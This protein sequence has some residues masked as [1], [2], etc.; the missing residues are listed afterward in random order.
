MKHDDVD[1]FA[2]LVMPGML[3]NEAANCLQIGLLE[4]I[5]RGVITDYVL[6]T[7]WSADNLTRP[8][9][10]VL[11]TPPYRPVLGEPAVDTSHYGAVIETL[12]DNLPPELPGVLGPVD[13]GQLFA[14]RYADK[15]GVN[16]ELTMAE[17]IHQCIAVEPPVQVPGRMI[18]AEE[19]YK[20]LLVDWWRAFRLETLPGEPDTAE[21]SVTRDLA[22][23]TGGIW[24]WEVE[25]KPVSVAGA[26]GP[27]P[28]G[29]RVGP[30]YTPP[31]ERRKG[32]AA[33]LVAQVTQLLLDEGRTTVFLFTDLANPTSNALY[34]RLGY[35][36]VA[37]RSMYDFTTRSS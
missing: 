13:L 21:A 32:Y 11:Q 26:R 30:V 2:R 27:T 28:N 34:Y 4:A 36:G 22:A 16:Y 10:S 37:D 7:V 9:L 17:R 20:P 12:V 18:R 31:A 35:R 8:V 25:G 6:G 3:E 19:R 23:T 15:H 14:V 5:Q 24:L 1:E 29:I 33:A